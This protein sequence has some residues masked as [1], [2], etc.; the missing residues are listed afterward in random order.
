MCASGLQR[1]LSSLD[2][3]L[4]HHPLSNTFS[5]TVVDA[6]ETAFQLK[7][8]QAA[9]TYHLSIR[10][11]GSGSALSDT[12]KTHSYLSKW[13]Q[14]YLH[15]AI[16]VVTADIKAGADATTLQ[17]VLGYLVRGAGECS[18]RRQWAF[19]Q[20]VNAA[21]DVL[22]RERG[23]ERARK[24]MRR[25]EGDEIEGRGEGEE[26]EEEYLREAL[27]TVIDERKT[28]ALHTVFLEPTLAYARSVYDSVMEGD[29]DVHGANTYLAVLLATLGVRLPRQAL[30]HDEVKAV[31]NFL[32]ADLT[33]TDSR[34]HRRPLLPSLWHSE[35]L[36][37]ATGSLRSN[38]TGPGP[39][40]CKPGLPVRRH[41]FF[42]QGSTALEVAHAAVAGWGGTDGERRRRGLAV[43]LAQFASYF[44]R[45]AMVERLVL[46]IMADEAM[47][48]AANRVCERMARV[49]ARARGSE[50][51]GEGGKEGESEGERG[52]AV[53]TSDRHYK[54]PPAPP[55]A[56]PE[57]QLHFGHVR[58]DHVRACCLTPQIPIPGLHRTRRPHPYHLPGTSRGAG[59]SPGSTGQIL[60]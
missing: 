52:A 3:L 2:H 58:S 49:G 53:Q 7:S 50:M 18:A 19:V 1:T 17:L 27:H 11:V 9:R 28:Q 13:Q 34:G 20:A 40:L 39:E 22:E 48:A 51:V 35:N 32:D 4:A 46:A 44:T 24:R 33:F 25:Q 54:T 15:A 37:R 47:L 56:L 55:D 42:F 5:D 12:L 26:E 57:T 30:L 21:R 16:R 23:R 10:D 14:R 43:I 6:I 45:E 59:T 41:E 38:V 36:G 60:L 31:V 29:V 8:T